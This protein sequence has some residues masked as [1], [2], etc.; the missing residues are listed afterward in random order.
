M[1]K[2]KAAFKSGNELAAQA[3][4]A[5]FFGAPISQTFLGSSESMVKVVAMIM[6]IL[7]RVL[8][9]QFLEII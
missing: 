9:W 6:I 5:E 2:Q 1:G 8:K 3:A 7:K 4:K